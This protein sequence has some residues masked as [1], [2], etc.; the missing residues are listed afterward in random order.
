LTSNTTG[1]FNSAFGASS[2]LINSTGLE[3][4]AIG[5]AALSAN[6]TGQFNTAVGF[7]ALSFTQ[8][9][10]E[11]T[12][13]GNSAASLHHLGVNNTIIGSN[14]DVG[15][16]GIFN[17]VVVGELGR[18]TGSNQ[19]RL[20]NTSTTSIGGVVGFTNLSDGRFKKNISDSVKGVDFIMRL[21]PVTYQLDI[22]AINKKL[23]I[24]SSENLKEF[25]KAGMAQNSKMVF[26]G[27]V[28][29][30]VEKAAKEAGYDFSGV[31][32]PKNEN[33][34]YGLRYSDFVV[35]L[36]KAIQEQQHMI[37]ELRKQNADLQKRMSALE[38][39]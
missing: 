9:S 25:A 6:T 22:D 27:F 18:A 17:S 13:V 32:K 21:R 39:K 10:D 24:N 1:F 28:A 26:S 37:D 38:H 12:V 33:D 31:D 2:L 20:G 11:N 14:A 8:T 5:G 15:F 16:D 3:N 29:Q 36:V 23:K 34:F 35:P 30:D 7:N 4:T 19:V